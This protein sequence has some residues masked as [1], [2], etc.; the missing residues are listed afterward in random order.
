MV[1]DCDHQRPLLHA[2]LDGTRIS[3]CCGGETWPGGCALRSSHTASLAAYSVLTLSRY[4]SGRLFAKSGACSNNLHSLMRC[5]AA[6]RVQVGAVC[7]ETTKSTAC[8]MTLW[9]LDVVY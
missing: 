5:D 7:M 4:A 9:F 8:E 2:W 6:M 3:Q 1:C